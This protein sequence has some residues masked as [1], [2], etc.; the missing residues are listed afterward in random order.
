MKKITWRHYLKNYLLHYIQLQLFIVLVTLP[1]FVA[2]GIPLSFALPLSNLIFNPFLGIF[3]FISSFIF[4]TELWGLPNIFFI[5]CLEITTKIWG[6]ILQQAK[7][8][9]LVGFISLN[10]YILAAVA[11]SPLLILHHKKFGIPV[12]ST[13]GFIL[14]C[15]IFF[16]YAT[17]ISQPFTLITT[18]NCCDEKI[19]LIRHNNQTMLLDKGALGKKISNVSWIEYTLLPTL[20]KTCGT[21]TVD[22]LIV[23]KPGI[24][25]LD[26]AKQLVEC[27]LVKNVYIPYWK[28]DPG[29]SYLKRYGSF[30]ATLTKHNAALQR[31]GNRPL[32]LAFDH[33]SFVVLNQTQQTYCYNESTY[34][35]TDVTGII[36][37][38]PIK[39]DFI[40][41]NID[42]ELVTN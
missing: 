2:W 6:W 39:I 32:Y 36:N 12:K 1:I 37:Q 17:Y 25:L 40:A 3:L 8:T 13:V 31:I 15:G 33:D 14:M 41:K 26:A 34:Q 18:I 4:F 27:T 23:L 42:N 24:L 21:S 11:V 19:I 29:K 7:P 30:L 10:P 35:G 5:T 9:W 16:I 38:K 22:H 20:I 28:G